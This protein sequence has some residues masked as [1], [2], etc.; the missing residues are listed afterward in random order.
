MS[1]T[2]INQTLEPIKRDRHTGSSPGE[3]WGDAAISPGAKGPGTHFSL[4]TRGNMV[5]LTPEPQIQDLNL[6]L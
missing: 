5:L 4:S 6:A 3:D 1:H 2:G